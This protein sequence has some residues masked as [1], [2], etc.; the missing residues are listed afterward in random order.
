MYS[1]GSLGELVFTN[2]PLDTKPEY[3]PKFNK[4]LF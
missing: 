2:C 4:E 1:I 3:Q